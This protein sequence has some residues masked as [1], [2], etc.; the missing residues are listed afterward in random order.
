MPEIIQCPTCR[1]E[2][3]IPEEFIGKPVKCPSCGLNFVTSAAAAAARRR[4]LASATGRCLFPTTPPPAYVAPPPLPPDRDRARP[5]ADRA[6][7]PPPPPGTD[8]AD[9]RPLSD[10]SRIDV[11]AG[12]SGRDARAVSAR[13]IPQG[14][15]GG[16]PAHRRAGHGAIHGHPQRPPCPRQRDRLRRARCR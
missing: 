12:G 15:G 13:A 7:D 4:C 6:G 3:Q 2:L 11:Q 9:V 14:D 5:R 16:N 8:V 1:R 10:S